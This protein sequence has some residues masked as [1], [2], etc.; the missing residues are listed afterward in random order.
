MPFVRGFELTREGGV[1]VTVPPDL[2]FFAGHF[3]GAPIVPG[4]ALLQLA[5]QQLPPCDAV[6]LHR[7]RFLRPV[8]PGAELTLAVHAAAGGE[9]TFTLHQGDEVVAHG[10]LRIEGTER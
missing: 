9:A 10:A 3:A 6:T 5:L 1:R 2:T 7:V 8:G 4:A